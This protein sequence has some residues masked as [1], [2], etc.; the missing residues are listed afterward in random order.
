MGS[1][2]GQ[3]RTSI[4]RRQQNATRGRKKSFISVHLGVRWDFFYS[5]VGA[6][7]F[8]RQALSGG[9][10][11]TF[12]GALLYQKKK[13]KFYYCPAFATKLVDKIGSGDTMLAVMSLCLKEGLDEELSLFFYTSPSP[14]YTTIVFY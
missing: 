13:K 10:M 1:L 9:A 7:A 3:L 11:E 6:I 12:N 14:T 2:A 8:T 5:T 4:I